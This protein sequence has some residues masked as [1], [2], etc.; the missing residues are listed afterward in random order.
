MKLKKKTITSQCTSFC[1]RQTKTKKANREIFTTLICRQTNVCVFICRCVDTVCV[2]VVV[3]AA[4][5]TFFFFSLL[6]HLGEKCG[7]TDKDWD[8]TIKKKNSSGV[9]KKV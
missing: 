3:C 2:C 1:Q 8:R 4:K 9:Q 7:Y 5:Y 6:K